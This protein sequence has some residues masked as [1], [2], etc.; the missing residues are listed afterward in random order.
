MSPLNISSMPHNAP[1]PENESE[2]LDALLHYDILDTTPEEE[3]DA[4]TKLASHICQ[5]P[6]ALIS[7][8]DGKRQWFKSKIGLDISETG[9]EISFCR[10]AIMNKEGLEVPN[11]L[12]DERFKDNPLV[13]GKPDIR[14]YAGVPL[15]N[16][17]GLNMG[18]LCVIDSVPRTLT[19]E[20]REALKVLSKQVMMHFELRK[21]NQLLKR[22]QESLKK[23]REMLQAISEATDEL[24]SNSDYLEAVHN[25]L[26]MLG[27]A[28]GIDCAYL[29]RVKSTDK[30]K[31]QV[32]EQLASWSAVSESK[33]VV[34]FQKEVALSLSEKHLDKLKKYENID[35]NESDTSEKDDLSSYLK[36]KHIN[37]SLILPVIIGGELWGFIGFG[38]LAEGHVWSESELS[39]FKS[40][41]NSVAN[42]VDRAAVAKQAE[43]MALFSLEN[44]FP[45]V[46]VDLNGKVLLR[47]APAEHISKIELNGKVYSDLEFF[48]LI[49]QQLTPVKPIKT[50]EVTHKQRHYNVIARLSEL[51]KHINIYATDV[52]HQKRAEELLIASEARMAAIIQNLQAGILLKDENRKVIHVNKKFHQLFNL[53]DSAI[54]PG[55]D[56][57]NVTDKIKTLFKDPKA[58]KN[59]IDQVVQEDKPCLGEEL[60]LADGRCFER[61]FI[62]I[63][64]NNTYK[65][66]LWKYMDVTERKKYETNLKTQEEKYRSIITNMNLGLLEVNNDNVILSANNT[67]S[68]ISGYSSEELVGNNALKLLGITEDRKN[69]IDLQGVFDIARLPVQNK[70]GE[71][72]WWLLSGTPNYN[73]MGQKTG[74][75]IIIL[76]IT[77]HRKL[78]EELLVMRQK[79]EE[80]AKAKEQFFANMSHEIRTPLNAIIG[81]VSELSR[82]DLTN[83]QKL[84]VTHATSA[85]Q[86]L[87]S[88]VNDILDIS[89]I[90]AGKLELD[91]SPFSLREVL[92][93]A[94]IIMKPAANEKLLNFNVSV[95]EK[96]SPAFLGDPI[97]IRQVLINL[98]GN[99]IKFTEKGSV[100]V[101]CEL[102]ER[103]SYSQKVKLTIADTGIGMD[104]AYLKDLFKKF[105]Q[106]DISTSRKYGGTGLGMSITYEL[107]QLMNGSIDVK[108][109]KGSG[110]RIELVLNF[111]VAN[112]NNVPASAVAGSTESLDGKR[113]LLVE[114]N[115]MNRMVAA[116]T[117][118]RYKLIVTEATNGAEAIERVKETEFD[119]ILMDLQMPV[120][121]GIEATKIIRTQL[122]LTTPIIAFTAN[123]FK[124]EI[125]QHLATGMNGYVTKPFEERVLLSTIQQMLYQT[126]GVVNETEE[127]QHTKLYDLS[128]LIAVS[129]GDMA[130]VRKM[131]DLFKVHTLSSVEEIKEAFNEKDYDKIRKVTHRI[132]PG[133]EKL[134]ITT[135]K[136]DILALEEF[137]TSAFTPTELHEAIT[138]LESTLAK[139]ISALANEEL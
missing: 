72:R 38:T 103:N 101:L 19:P 40:F 50:W 44:P 73:D 137:D 62:P 1:V 134:G 125:E 75:I 9:R 39:L 16:P 97:R 102:M 26:P 95:S 52:T 13:T 111:T 81:M 53:P 14:F 90:E 109:E 33:E 15:E 23:K 88:L 92:R 60:E 96:V 65:G 83:R 37:S 126:A 114:D 31:G 128:K 84:F 51:K 120:M 107:V 69:T 71:L 54:S 47:N 66:H 94:E 117:L 91:S 56:Y 132:K 28:A 64:I 67:F 85:S 106:E 93:E 116:N 76:D 80:S 99:A 10:Y 2:R 7:I 27:S 63:I 131:V 35:L 57:A 20:Q 5:T 8:L 87:L 122:H 70:R 49:A 86:H 4:I 6:I 136:A 79:A 48:S 82:E 118:Q 100:S 104:E 55:E 138:R 130:F 123:A 89:K 59:R 21:Q 61:D 18:T 77:R 110:T 58:Y 42:A 22:E 74:A 32:S 112:E 43:D 98:I 121:D 11:A 115:E 133:I 12:K 30:I 135:L 68:N 78:E 29:F 105:T 108:S 113:V 25:C 34:L 124:S 36:A 127:L 41:A 46:R 129:H 45:V 17:E 139:V 24:L 3:L 119:L